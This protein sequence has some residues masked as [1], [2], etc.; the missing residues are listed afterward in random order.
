[1]FKYIPT[2]PAIKS[3]IL[4]LTIENILNTAERVN[5]CPKPLDQLPT[6]HPSPFISSHEEKNRAFCLAFSKTKGGSSKEAIS[7][8]QQN[9][10]CH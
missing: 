2:Y 5:V 3:H 7:N 4:L 1:V 8:H 9:V 6:G 10:A